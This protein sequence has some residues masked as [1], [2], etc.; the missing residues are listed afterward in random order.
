MGKALD[1][2]GDRGPRAMLSVRGSGA[3]RTATAVEAPARAKERYELRFPASNGNAA[4]Q[5]QEWCELRID[6]VCRRIRFHDYHEIYAV[7]GLYEELFYERLECDS[8]R[9]V[10]ELLADELRIRRRSAGALSVLEVGAG[11]GMVAEELQRLGVRS[12]VGIDIIEEAA[13]AA[14]RDRPGVYDDYLVLD[15]TDVPA[16]ERRWLSERRFD[17]LLTVAALGFGDIPPDAFAT[18]YNFIEPGGLI[19]FNIKEDFLT[20]RDGS[21]FCRLVRRAFADRTMVLQ[22][23]HRY[24]HRLSTAGDP[25]HYVAMVA[26]KRADLPSRGD[27]R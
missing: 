17:C 4:A 14:E 15:L 6:G 18:A 27:A 25:L 23:E 1:R 11:N 24:R 22:A 10:C 7:P 13:E 26:E 21:G 19:A 9:T 20:D 12:I 5:D 3:S 2:N 8:P 16:A